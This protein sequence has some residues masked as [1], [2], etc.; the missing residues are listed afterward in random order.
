MLKDPRLVRKLGFFGVFYVIFMIVMLLGTDAARE[1]ANPIT[2]LIFPINPNQGP[3]YRFV[4]M[5]LV[6]WGM[7]IGYLLIAGSGKPSGPR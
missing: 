3:L 4:S 6:Y 5:S 7:V 1:Y 2:S